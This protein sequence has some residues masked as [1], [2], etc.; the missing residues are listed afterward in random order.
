MS[1]H[2]CVYLQ[3]VTAYQSP[4]PFVETR[5]HASILVPAQAVRSADQPLCPLFTN[6][7]PTN[8]EA[9]HPIAIREPVNS[10]WRRRRDSN[11]RY[12][13]GAY[14]GLANRR[15][16]PLGHVSACENPYCLRT[17]SSNAALNKPQPRRPR[18]RFKSRHKPPQHSLWSFAIRPIHTWPRRSC[19]HNRN[20]AFKCLVRSSRKSVE[21]VYVC[22]S[23]RI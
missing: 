5:A 20:I 16:Q 1:W 18:R 13:F 17:F 3:S 8:F 15:L 12:A 2:I 6:A 22:G 19:A 11:P 10:R 4:Q 14:N 21:S 23:H 9:A 7:V